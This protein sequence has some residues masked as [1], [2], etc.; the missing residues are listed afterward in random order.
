MG[1]A[2]SPSPAHIKRYLQFVIDDPQSYLKNTDIIEEDNLLS[3]I[4]SFELELIVEKYYEN[5]LD[6]IKTDLQNV[7]DLSKKNNKKKKSITKDQ[8]II[9]NIK[10]KVN[11]NKFAHR[12]SIQLYNFH[13]NNDRKHPQHYFHHQHMQPDA[14]NTNAA[15]AI[16]C[17]K[18]K[19]L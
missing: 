11:E 6:L 17:T 8:I 14:T 3:K 16:Q 19:Q 15:N 5:Y 18:C 7:F 13:L 4:D 12:L 1:S 10:K 2:V 9:N